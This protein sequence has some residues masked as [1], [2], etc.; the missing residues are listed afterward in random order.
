MRASILPLNFSPYG[1]LMLLGIAVSVVF[2]ARL[3]RRD[4]RLMLVYVAALVGAF[5]GAKVAYVIA[6]GWMDFGNR[7]CGGG[8]QPVNPSSARS[9]AATRRWNWQ[10]SGPAIAV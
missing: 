5:L 6:D 9:S 4:D 10:R 1:W 7:T 3:A 8:W 2:W